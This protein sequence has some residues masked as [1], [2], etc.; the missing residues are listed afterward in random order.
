MNYQIKQSIRMQTVYTTEN[1]FVSAW[2]SD[3]AYTEVN[4]I[5][6][7]EGSVEEFAEEG[8]SKRLWQIFSVII[9]VIGLTGNVLNM[10]V[11]WRLGIRKQ[12]TLVFILFLAVTDS[13]VL[14]SGL[15]R[16][17][18]LSTFDYDTRTIS[19][20]VC[21]ISLFS[22]YASMQYSAW[23]LVGVCSERVMK[24]YFP[25]KYRRI[26]SVK[27]VSIGLLILLVCVCIVDIHFFWTNGINDFTN[28]DCS[29][30]TEHDFYFDENVFVYIDFT[31]L[32]AIPFVIM[33]ICNILLARILKKIQAK[34]SV[35]MHY[36]YFKRTQQVSVK[37]TRM[38]LITSIYFIIATAP[39]SIYFIVDTYYRPKFN[40]HEK[41][42]LDLAWAIVYLFQ[43][44]NYSVNFY[45]YAACNRRF[46][47]E[48]KA[49]F[50]CRKR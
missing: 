49:I 46:Q 11:L 43:F 2:N 12:P 29:S 32:S 9:F 31:F 33:L 27:S 41:A 47:Q 7:T 50:C 45:L 13:V 19:N 34:R 42:K 21:K 15:P 30:L 1:H 14:I 24:T 22:I 44:S 10:A 38:L 39:I 40:N 25:F 6:T 4:V 28:G 35:M 23:I 20:I 26:F 48:I 8:V 37:M 5:E 16:Y 3:I 36:I 17:W 18:I